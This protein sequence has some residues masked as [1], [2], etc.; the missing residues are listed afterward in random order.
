[1]SATE[2]RDYYQV[3][4][5]PR[6]A[7]A[8]AIKEAFRRLAMR[9]HPDRNK[10]PDAESR[11]KEIAKA[12]AV[13]SD[14]KKRKQ[15]DAQGHAGVAGFSQED[16][17]G[18]IDFADL[19]EGLGFDFSGLAGSPFEAF[20]RGRRGHPRH[21]PNQEVE[22]LVPLERVAKGGD[23]LLR[24]A[25]RERCADCGGTGAQAGTAPRQ[26]GTCKGSGEKVEERK[27]DGI[28]FRQVSVCPDCAGRGV[29]ID[30]PCKACAG[31]GTREHEASVRLHIPPGVE[32]GMVLRVAGHGLPSEGP[33][34]RPGDLYVA[35]HTLSDPRFER[36]GTDLL[37]SETV[38]I[39]EAVLGTTLE[40]PTL[41]GPASLEVPPATQPGTLLRL[42]GRGLPEFRG[43]RHGDLLV[44][45]RV[46]V[47][48]SLSGEELQLYRRLQ[49][50]GRRTARAGTRDGKT[51]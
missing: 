17:Y 28:S 41:D 31:A 19:F 40:V 18:G 23:E 3:L 45:L 6:D 38:E 29:V 24:Y 42:P 10:A 8:K 46:H 48:N 25:R 50:L 16:L 14:P 32:E 36:R 26:C 43:Q 5:I 13:L 47:P 27:S 9:Y 49:E 12:Y 22:L 37:R 34:G 7:T 35:V 2:Q 11:F 33:D 15:Y 39:P 20:F 1:M 44:Q 21:G 51:R 4:G 30:K